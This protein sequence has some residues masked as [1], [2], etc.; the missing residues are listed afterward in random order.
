MSLVRQRR[1]DAN[2]L[3]FALQLCLLRHP[4]ITLDD[5]TEVPL[6]MVSWVA[7]RLAISSEVWNEYATRGETRQEHGREI[8]A[9]LGMSS[10]GIADF[11][12]LVEHVGGVAAQTDQGLVLVETARD[13]LHS[14]KVGAPGIGIIERACAQA[15]IR[16][17]RRIHAI[18]GDNLSPGHRRRLDE[19]LLRRPDSSLTEIG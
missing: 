7:A 15:L 6:E 13:F 1:G 18:L 3:G 9:Y 19:L 2:R 4:G 14:R 5:D 12:R 16:A 17:N 11:R 10:F 8:R